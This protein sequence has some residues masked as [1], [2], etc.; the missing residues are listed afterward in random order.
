[1]GGF[2][3]ALKQLSIGFAS[4]KGKTWIHTGGKYLDWQY[5]MRKS[6]NQEDFTASM[7]DAASTIVDYFK[8]G[9][10]GFIS[11]LANISKSCD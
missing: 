9:Q 7:A 5:A 3:G 6:A 4:Q 11:V 2:G 10:I 1:M 8:K